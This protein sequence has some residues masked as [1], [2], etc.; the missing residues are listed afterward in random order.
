MLKMRD[1]LA[2]TA[3]ILVMFR[4]KHNLELLYGSLAGQSEKDFRIYFTDNNP[5]DSDSEFSKKLNVKYGLDITYLHSGG[6]Y[7]FAR[8]NNIAA[9]QAIEDGCKYLFFL[10]NDTILDNKCIENLIITAQSSQSIAAVSPLIMYWKGKKEPGIIQEFGAMADFKSYTISKNFEGKEFSA[11]EKNISPAL[12]VDMLPG[13]ATFIKSAALKQTGLWEEKYFAYGDEIDLAY[14][15]RQAGYTCIAVKD[16]I[17]WHNHKWSK[18][19]KQGYYFEY[20]LIQRNKYLYFRK[21]GFYGKMIISYFLD[22]VK[23]PFRL[24]W[25]IKVCD[26]KLGYYYLKGTYAGLFG[27]SGKPNLGFIK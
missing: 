15:I 2:K 12:T 13:A 17:L 21:F 22:S 3:V 25:F 7:G 5:D 8:G 19:N 10:N 27:H 24:F 1:T 16:A 6:N 14:R 11:I 4:Q 23:F 9:Q 18:E 20:Y 26:L